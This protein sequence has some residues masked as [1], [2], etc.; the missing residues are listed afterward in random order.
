[1][2][3]MSFLDWDASVASQIAT[4]IVD[5]IPF[6]LAT[7][8]SITVGGS[9]TGFISPS[10]DIDLIRVSV[11]A[12]QTYVVSMR[13]TGTTALTDPFLVLR[14]N[15]GAVVAGKTD[16]DGGNGINSLLTFTAGYTGDYF[17]DAR[18]FGP[19]D[20]GQ[21]TLDVRQ[22]GAD[23]PDTFAGAV[24]LALDST[25]FG[26]I[27]ADV[28]GPYGPPLGD[29]DT[30]KLTAVTNGYITVEVAGGAD[31]A[32]NYLALPAG[33][34]DTVL[35]IYNSAG[36]VVASNDD[37]SFPSDISS[38]IGFFAN[39]GETY[40]IDV[41]TYRPWTG[42]Y[43][44]TTKS[45]DLTGL[46][47]LDAIN[48]FS[49]DNIDVEPGG[50]VKVYFAIPGET[51]GEGGASYGWNAFEKQQVLL[52]LNSEYGKILGY[53]Y[54]ETATSA[55]AEFRLITTTSTQFGAYFYPQDPD[56]GTQQGIGAFNVNS[57]G[58]DKAGFSTQNLPGDQVSLLQ[59]GYSFAVILHEF[60]HAH[61]LAHPHDNGGGSE[62][63]PGVFGPDF[64]GV[65]DLNQGVYTVMSYNDAYPAGPNG[66]TP[67]TVGNIDSGWSGTL[68]AFDIAALQLR[69][70]INNPYATGNTVYEL[71]DSNDPGTYYQT[72]WDTGG[73]DEIR[74]NGNR[75]A[76]IDLLAATIDYTPT[77]GGVVSYV[78]TIFGGYT[79]AR[80]VVIENA[81][82][83]GGDD[84]II[85]NAVANVLKGNGG[86]DWLMGREGGDTLNGG[87]GFDTASYRD[88]DAGVAASL[89]TNTGT[90]GDA[91]GDTF[92]S[93]EKLEGSQFADVL[94]SGNGND[95]LSGLGG[96]DQLTG[97]NGDDTL[98][99]GAGNDTLDGGNNN[100]NLDGG[101]DNDTLNGGN[102]NDTLNGG[103]GNDTLNGGNHNDL[104]NGGTGNDI[105]T[106]GNQNDI[107]AFSDLGGAD[108]IT[109]FK[110]GQDII[111]L[112]AIDAVAGGADNAFS[113]I[114]ASA[115]SSVAGQLRS[116]SSGGNNFLAGDVNGDGVAD[117]TIQTNILI[118]S[119]DVVL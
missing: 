27:E 67:F 15:T 83:G 43:A 93:I 18:S 23:V 98:Q 1:M 14:T 17:I 42:G 90:S 10:G 114:G 45:V 70:G 61:G 48:W 24:N 78:D 79:I 92:I 118:I 39:A 26:F 86:D 95:T 82:G 102:H 57:G 73:V 49:A 104:L 81:S 80:G 62:I 46:D 96:N 116:F 99:G 76:V 84:V 22:Q 31:Y 20:T 28:A 97:G 53:T 87:L 100:D 119:A 115:F 40:Y 6:S 111:D 85:G 56:Y 75:D 109:D 35:I 58:W 38:G 54:V 107:F 4:G 13:G 12:G 34:I 103:S 32:S 5:T 94:V 112:S 108:Q 105:L 63:M 64:F 44:I 106:G 33:E 66:P 52:A 8:F 101:A 50:I 65:F 59:G 91:A 2:S 51:F 69:Y 41:T 25:S 77:G 88:A 30:Y 19:G 60:G 72:I 47:P 7:P 117:F 71:K 110:R 113:F 29:V 11:T 36:Q 9:F 89:A 3:D 55:E 37:I 68:S 74:Y 16:D 21:Y